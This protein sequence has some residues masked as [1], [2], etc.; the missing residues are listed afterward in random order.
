MIIRWVDI[1]RYGADTSISKYL[2]D[3]LDLLQ[4]NILVDLEL[5]NIFVEKIVHF[6]IG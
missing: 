3:V 4:G 1:S 2:I 6:I 5:Y